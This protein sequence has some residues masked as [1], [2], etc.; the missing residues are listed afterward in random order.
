MTDIKIY[1]DGQEISN[2]RVA[3]WEL[4]RLKREYRFLSRHGIAFDEDFELLLDKGD[5]TAA[6]IAIGKTK[7]LYEPSIFRKMLKTR[8]ALGNGT[9]RIAALISRGKRRF[10]ITELVVEKSAADPIEVMRQIEDVMLINTTDHQAINLAAT[11]DHFVLL[12][13]EP[14]VQEVLEITGGSPLPTRFFA[15]YGDE[16]GLRS[17][18]DPAFDAQAAGAARLADGTIIGG[19]RHQIKR[20]GN[21]LRFRAL[22]EFPAVL[23]T[24]MIRMHQIHLAC[25]FSRWLEAVI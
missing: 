16:T 17:K 10:S 21:G 15:N 12:G 6:R 14:N 25:E 18:F 7:A 20:E 4:G 24:H 23:P 2:Q 11:P 8:V 1:I 5:V 19:V 3:D 22:V 9:S 13:T